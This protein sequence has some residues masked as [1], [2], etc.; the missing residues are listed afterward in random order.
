MGQQ[1]SAR[2]E[3]LSEVDGVQAKHPPQVM[4]SRSLQQHW[5]KYARGHVSLHPQYGQ[6]FGFF[7]KLS[8]SHGWVVLN[9]RLQLLAM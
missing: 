9:P 8:A 1:L 2:I 7:A 6:I 3:L 5:Q 4:I